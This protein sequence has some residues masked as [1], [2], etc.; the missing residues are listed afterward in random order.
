MPKQLKLERKSMKNIVI[1]VGVIASIATSMAYAQSRPRE[2]TLADIL[3]E[4]VA[5]HP[6]ITSRQSEREASR[7]D[8]ES[9]KWGRY[10]TLSASVETV[11]GGMQTLASIQQPLWT[12][13]R[14]TGQIDLATASES[15]SGANVAEAELEILKQTSAVYF[16][17][18]RLESRLNSAKSN[19][20]EHLKL[21]E[22][23]QRRVS[24][25]VSPITDETQANTR[26]HQAVTER[27]HIERQLADAHNALEQLLGR[28]APSIAPPNAINLEPRTQ[29]SLKQAAVAY[30]PVRKRLAAQVEKSGAEIKLAR[31]QIM[32]TLYA[33]YETVLGTLHSGQDRDRA[34]VALRAESGS[35]FSKMSASKAAVARKQAAQDAINVFD[36]ELAQ[37]VTASWIEAKALEQQVKPARDTLVGADEIVASY[38]RQFQVGKKTWLDVLNAQREKANSQAALADI[39]AMLMMA[40]VRLLILAGEINAVSAEVLNGQVLN[41]Q[42][43]SGR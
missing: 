10:P 7:F 35:G 16:E 23:I 6:S 27:I 25:E 34:Y 40:K 17:I 41:G 24:V 31:A 22:T 30:S 29:V 26:F 33:G 37:Q 43:L 8:L 38:L 11:K 12:G 2:E 14:M 13:G 32:P 5:Q 19:V 21:L 18:M 4:A 42:V 28:P 20:A 39:E 15:M 36:R 3:K 9:A 1:L